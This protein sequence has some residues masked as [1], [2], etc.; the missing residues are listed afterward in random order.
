MHQMTQS[1]L[2]EGR[3]AAGR[4]AWSKALDLLGQA[5]TRESLGPDDLMLLADSAWWMGKM[6]ECIAARE[7]AYTAYLEQGRPRRAAYVALKLVDH[8]TDL[9]EGGVAA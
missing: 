2:I 3:E 8:H 6:R 5:G 4:Y 9:A 1:A 7:R